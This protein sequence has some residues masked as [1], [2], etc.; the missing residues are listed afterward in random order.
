MCCECKKNNGNF[1]YIAYATDLNGSNFS[2]NRTANS[3]NRCYQAIYV[4]SVELDINS[5]IFPNYFYGRFYNICAQ[6][7]LNNYFLPTPQIAK[8]KK[9]KR[10]GV[11]RLLLDS[12]SPKRQTVEDLLKIDFGRDYYLE[13]L[14]IYFNSFGEQNFWLSLPDKRLELCLVSNKNYKSRR[15]ASTT[16]E[17]D[18]SFSNYKKGNKD[19]FHNAIVHPANTSKKNPEITGTIY[20]GGNQGDPNEQYTNNPIDTRILPTEWKINENDFSFGDSI[21]ASSGLN[22]FNNPNITIQID[23]RHLFRLTAREKLVYPHDIENKGRVKVKNIGWISY[24]SRNKKVYK[25]NSILYFRLSAGMPGTLNQTTGVYQKRIFSDLSI[26][27]YISPKIARFMSI[28]DNMTFFMYGHNLS[29]GA[30]K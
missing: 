10:D 15:P 16:T 30:K 14:D 8:R 1:T 19:S 27:I 29:L 17:I 11:N 25:R 20:S 5:S 9:Q 7:N 18:W 3:I 4:S 13:Q 26:P 12:I 28:G 22:R 23:V 24:N 6:S 21:F 2:L